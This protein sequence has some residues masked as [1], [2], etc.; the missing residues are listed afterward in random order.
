MLDISLF[1]ELENLGVAS[2]LL[3]ALEHADYVSPWGWRGVTNTIWGKSEFAKHKQS[4][5]NMV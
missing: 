3:G 5:K 2:E 1:D 4:H